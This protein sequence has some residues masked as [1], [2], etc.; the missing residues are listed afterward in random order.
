MHESMLTKFI[1]GS[2]T[3]VSAPDE[4]IREAENRLR[5]KFPPDYISLLKR[6]NGGEGFVNKGQYLMLWT[7]ES[8]VE[9]NAKYNEFLPGFLIFGSN[10]GGEAF[11]YDMRQEPWTIV[12]VP[13]IVMSWEDAQLLGRTIH[14]FFETLGANI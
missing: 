9:W 3:R 4:A 5:V 13:F 10:G 6:C 2:L 8:L 11:G 7:V 1:T 14:E 12:Q